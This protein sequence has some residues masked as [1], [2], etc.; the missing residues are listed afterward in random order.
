M[1]LVPAGR[2]FESVSPHRPQVTGGS[3]RASPWAWGRAW[4]SPG[5]RDTTLEGAH[6]GEGRGL[7]CFAHIWLEESGYCLQVVCPNGL[8]VF[9]FFPQRVGAPP[10]RVSRQ[11]VHWHCQVSGLVSSSSEIYATEGGARAS[12]PCP[13]PVRNP[14]TVR[15]V[16]C[17]FR[18]PSCALAA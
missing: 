14:W 15:L 11:P 1:L 8:S 10:G 7:G 2:G 17:A 16:L 9:R 6:G 5:P 12:P 3:V 18:S 13:S 4:P